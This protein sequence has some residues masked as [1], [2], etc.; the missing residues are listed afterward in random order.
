MNQDPV[1][2]EQVLV[3]REGVIRVHAGHNLH[4]PGIG[5][6]QGNVLAGEPL[7]DLDA[8]ARGASVVPVVIN[9]PKVAPPVVEEHHVAVLDIILRHPLGLQGAVHVLHSDHGSGVQHLT[10]VAVY[11]DQDSPGEDG[12]DALDPEILQAVGS[13]NLVFG[14]SVVEPLHAVVDV[15][16]VSQAVELGPD[17]AQLAH[18]EL[19]VKDQATG[20]RVRRWAR[21]GW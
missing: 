6:D 14:E 21:R 19:I 20:E 5:A 12:L 17:L 11:V 7:C 9:T 18:D 2:G 1:L 16:N 8:Y 15:A 13:P 3:H 4:G 10:L